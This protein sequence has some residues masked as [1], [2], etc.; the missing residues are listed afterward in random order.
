MT[1]RGFAPQ[2]PSSQEVAAHNRE[3]PHIAAWVAAISCRVK[4]PTTGYAPHAPISG[5]FTRII[6]QA[7]DF[8]FQPIPPLPNERNEQAVTIDRACYGFAFVVG[9]LG[10]LALLAG[11]GIGLAF[12]VLAALVAGLGVAYERVI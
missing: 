4:P 1:A 7:Q 11:F 12:L 6:G 3:D 5:Y 10:L 2:P 8:P 9:L